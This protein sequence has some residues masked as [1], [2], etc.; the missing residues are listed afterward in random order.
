[1]ETISIYEYFLL[2]ATPKGKAAAKSPV[3]KKAET[4]PKAEPKPKKIKIE[5]E[6]TEEKVGILFLLRLFCFHWET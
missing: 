1:M 5:E 6:P 4:K 3:A 2:S